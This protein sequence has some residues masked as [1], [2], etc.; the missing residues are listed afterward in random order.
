MLAT[1]T[2]EVRLQLRQMDLW[3]SPSRDWVPSTSLTYC[4]TFCKSITFLGFT[5][6]RD[7]PA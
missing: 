4:V 5:L 2:S 1:R 3:E 7:N 6:K